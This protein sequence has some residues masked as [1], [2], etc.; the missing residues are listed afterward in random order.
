MDLHAEIMNIPARVGTYNDE[1]CYK[2]GHRDARHDAAELALKAQARIEEL[3]EKAKELDV[4]SRFAGYLLD[5]CEG[6]TIYE[7]NLQYWLSD[8]LKKEKEQ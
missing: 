3:E 2:L 6:Q 8:M 5:N 4:W 1:Y 7:E